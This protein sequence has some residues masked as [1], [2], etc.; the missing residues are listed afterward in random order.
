MTCSRLMAALVVVAAAAGCFFSGFSAYDSVQHLDR[1][2]HGLHCSFVPGFGRAV[3]DATSGCHVMMMSPYSSVFRQHVWGGIPIAILAMSVFAFLLYWSLT[4]AARGRLGDRR[5]TGFLLTATLLPL[6]ASCG[7]AAVAITVLHAVCKLCVGIYAASVLAFVGALVLWLCARRSGTASTAMVSIASLAGA[8]ALGVVFVAA[9]VALYVVAM[10]DYTRFV[11]QCGRL[12]HPEDPYGV[13]IPMDSRRG[14][15]SAIEVLDPLCP[16][17]RAFEQRLHASGLATRVHRDVVLFPLDDTCNWM[18]TQAVHPGACAISE[19][20]L[21]AGAQAPEVIAWA[22]ESQD[23]IRAQ[24]AH[25]RTAAQRIASARFP[26]L[27][28]CIGSAG[29]RARLNRSLRWTVANHLPVLTPQLYVNGVK[30]C[31]EDTD[32]G[33]DFA[34]SR[35][36]TR[37]GSTEP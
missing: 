11:G 2:V 4:L 19:A 9:P 8:F 1:D 36:L 23:R 7:M 27:A 13:R 31:D 30:L 20:V 32:L 28:A 33:M 15:V 34:L 5:A 16:A 25:D 17:C 35:L 3:T 12:E 18:L 24:A 22:L 14:S 6:G 29:V 37:S 26:N 10:P 21:C